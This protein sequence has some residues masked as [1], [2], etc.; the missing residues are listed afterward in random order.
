MERHI[1]VV[2]IGECDDIFKNHRQANRIRGRTG[3]GD[4]YHRCL[5]RSFRIVAA[6]VGHHVR[7]KLGEKPREDK[8]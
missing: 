2:G 3:L 6:S 1:A 4:S 7:N 5:G 8:Q